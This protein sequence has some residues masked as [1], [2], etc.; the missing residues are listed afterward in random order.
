LSEADRE[1]VVRN[2]LKSERLDRMPTVVD[3]NHVAVALLAHFYE[4]PGAADL[5]YEA[6]I[7][8]QTCRPLAAQAA[9]P[10]PILKVLER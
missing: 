7:G 1:Q 9:K 10:R 6:Q 2:A 5:C 4:S 3:A 8:R